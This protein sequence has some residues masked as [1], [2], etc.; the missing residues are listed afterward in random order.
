MLNK[1]KVSNSSFDETLGLVKGCLLLLLRFGS[2]TVG[3]SSAILQLRWMLVFGSSRIFALGVYFINQIK[4]AL[5]DR[6][7]F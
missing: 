4:V 3:L 1:T 5:L 2:F 7:F 6:L